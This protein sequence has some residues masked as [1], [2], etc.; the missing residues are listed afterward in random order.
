[1]TATS[2]DTSKTSLDGATRIAKALSH[3]LRAKILSRLNERVASPN[4]LSQELGEPL[5]N[6]SYHVR[7]LLDLECVEL[8]DTAPRRGAIE[9]YYRAT[10]RSLGDD[11]VWKALPPS[12]RRGFAADWFKEAFDDAREAVDAGGFEERADCQL[13]FTRLYLDE[14]SWNKLSKRVEALRE[15]ALELQE[16][17]PAKAAAGDAVDTHLIL[18]QYESSAR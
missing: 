15:Y 6:V 12:A 16:K 8:V 7:A 2:T 4:E 10:Q 5:G 14:R 3:P 18:A 11:S 13:S 9:H 1:M 17:H